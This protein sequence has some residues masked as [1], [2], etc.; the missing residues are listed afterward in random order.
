MHAAFLVRSSRTLVSL[1]TMSAAFAAGA[2]AAAAAD[3]T[4][5]TITAEATTAPNAN[6][7]YRSNVRVKFTCADAESKIASST[8]WVR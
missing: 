8:S 7:W 3:T 6:G 1:L 5:P 2:G 4:P